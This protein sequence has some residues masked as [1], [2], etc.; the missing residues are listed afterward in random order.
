M[1][2][3][4]ALKKRFFSASFDRR[5]GN[6]SRCANYVQFKVLQRLKKLFQQFF[7]KK[8]KMLKKIFKKTV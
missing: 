3:E 4:N 6:I 5:V 7:F 2:V 8:F 1:S